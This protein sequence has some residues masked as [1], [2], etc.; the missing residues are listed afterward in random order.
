MRHTSD[1]ALEVGLWTC[2]L[3]TGASFTYRVGQVK[4]VIVVQSWLV[5]FGRSAWDLRAVSVFSMAYIIVA[6]RRVMNR[7]TVVC[8][9]FIVFVRW[10]KAWFWICRARQWYK[11]LVTG[12]ECAYSICDLSC[13]SPQ[14][15]R[16]LWP[17]LPLYYGT[18]PQRLVPWRFCG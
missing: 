11:H 6:R 18:W 12:L 14:C 17:G 10:W 16:I 9:N 1:C 4:I 15:H 13:I 7:A 3:S 5:W 8:F 2:P